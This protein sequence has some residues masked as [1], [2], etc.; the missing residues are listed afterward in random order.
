MGYLITLK[1][2]AISTSF[3]LIGD[4][5]LTWLVT[6]LLV[7]I[8]AFVQSSMDCGYIFSGRGDM[9]LELNM[10]FYIFPVSYSYQSIVR[11]SLSGESMVN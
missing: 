10:I 5:T 4:E 2:V 1:L 11:N 7:D 6:N 9:N 8:E 3:L